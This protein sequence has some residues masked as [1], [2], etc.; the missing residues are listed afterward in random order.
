M[1]Q[2]SYKVARLRRTLVII[3]LATIPFYLLGFIALWVA[4]ASRNTQ[5]PTPTL[6]VIYVTATSQPTATNLPPTKYPTHTPTNTATI[7]PTPT[8][9]PIPTDTATIAPTDTATD[10][11]TTAVPPT[12]TPTEAPTA[13]TP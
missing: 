5:T 9:T 12:D 6:N 3:I 13:S 8:E 1:E 4:D 2:T 11:P 10:I 7:T